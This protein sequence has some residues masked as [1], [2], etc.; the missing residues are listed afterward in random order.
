VASF[1]I[2]DTDR[3]LILH[4]HDPESFESARGREFTLVEVTALPGRSAAA[5][6]ALYAA[7]VQ[8]LE[9]APGIAPAKLTIIVHEP[10]LE[11]WG[12]RGG[13]PATDVELGFKLDV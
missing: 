1:K 7:I 2:P 13:R 3:N 5:K 6:R 4:E 8:N 11:N 12:I 9:R 10:P